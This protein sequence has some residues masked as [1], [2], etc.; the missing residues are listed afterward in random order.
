MDCVMCHL[1][2]SVWL[3][4]LEIFDYKLTFLT[5]TSLDELEQNEDEQ[6][7]ASVTK[8]GKYIYTQM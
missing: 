8:E 4:D 7:N 2:V 3:H 5:E 6:C 1:H